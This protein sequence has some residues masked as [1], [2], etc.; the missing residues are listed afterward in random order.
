MAHLFQFLRGN[1]GR[2]LVFTN[3]IT[4]LRRVTSTLRLLQVANVESLHGTMQQSQRLKHLDR[5]RKNTNS[6][7]VATD[8]A[9]RGL[10]IPGVEFVVE[11]RPRR[12]DRGE[13]KQLAVHVV[14]E[15]ELHH[16]RRCAPRWNFNRLLHPLQVAPGCTGRF[17]VAFPDVD[18]ACWA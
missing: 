7:L 14:P 6:V 3:T 9:A 12:L 17:L 18:S 13:A 1:K 11:R 5:F 15:F 2:T 8:V 4:V 10:D 16:G